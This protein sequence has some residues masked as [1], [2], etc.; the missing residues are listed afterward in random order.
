MEKSILHHHYQQRQPIISE[1]GMICPLAPEITWSRDL[2]AG[3][4]YDGWLI[5]FAM[6]GADQAMIFREFGLWQSSRGILLAGRNITSLQRGHH[7]ATTMEP[8]LVGDRLD[9]STVIY[10]E[11]TFERRKGTWHVEVI[12]GDPPQAKQP[13]AHDYR[14]YQAILANDA[15]HSDAIIQLIK[16]LFQQMLPLCTVNGS[17]LVTGPAQAIFEQSLQQCQSAIEQ[18]MERTKEEQWRL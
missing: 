4:R 10:A 5:P 8:I 9:G 18:S 7:Q 11:N 16:Q 1:V 6:S 15:D 2:K 13:S 17:P 12:Y 3:D 14:Y